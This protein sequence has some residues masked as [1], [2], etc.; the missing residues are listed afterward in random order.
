MA[1]TVLRFYERNYHIFA[2][3]EPAFQDGFFTLEHQ[4]KLLQLERDM[5]V[6]GSMIRFWIF[7]KEEKTHLF[8]SETIA[9]ISLRD[10]FHLYRQS[11][12]LGYKLDFTCWGK[13]Y[14]TEA[15]REAIRIAFD[16]VELHRIV[17]EVQTDNTRSIRI[18]E[19]LGFVQEGI[20]RKSIFLNGD[21]RDHVRYSILSSESHSES[22]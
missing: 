19:N 3:L 16:E 4:E 8:P 12:L 18:L 17:A 9:T 5:A 7:P 6:Q 1:P 22:L 2:P 13:G 15:L 11:C 14:M 20:E 21:W 10:I